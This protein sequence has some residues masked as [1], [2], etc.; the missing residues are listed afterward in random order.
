[1]CSTKEAMA[2]PSGSP[3]EAR[4][5]IMGGTIPQSALSQDQPELDLPVSEG[6]DTNS[7][8]LSRAN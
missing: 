5:E 6:I 1:M 4:G 8:S 7:F 3:W 2:G